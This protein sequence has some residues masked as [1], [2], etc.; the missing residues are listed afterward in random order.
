MTRAP[1]MLAAAALAV[2][3]TVAAAAPPDLSGVW[4]LDIARSTFGKTVGTAPLARRDTLV[5][6]GVELEV[7]SHIEKQND[8]QRLA[9][10]YR[11]DGRETVNPVSGVDV[12]SVARWRGAELEIKSRARM[13]IIDLEVDER[14]RLENG[15]QR[16]RIERV[17]KSP[18][19]T[20]PQTL[21]F[22]RR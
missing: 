12:K 14:W 16:L 15:G 11:L 4:E 2:C 21:V 6:R 8:I 18:L 20:Q 5:Q 22:V 7:R 3:T 10:R 17:S 9:Y 19:G 13:V 1:A